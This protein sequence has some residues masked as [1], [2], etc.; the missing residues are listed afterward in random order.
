M[1][2]LYFVS[3]KTESS[4]DIIEEEN[5]DF[6]RDFTDF[7]KEVTKDD[8]TAEL[9]ANA[10]NIF[11]LTEEAA[12]RGEEKQLMARAPELV[13]AENAGIAAQEGNNDDQDA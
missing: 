3:D 2:R 5:R 1:V 6:T 11:R 13:S 10:E 4:V 8:V 7:Y 9:L 12:A